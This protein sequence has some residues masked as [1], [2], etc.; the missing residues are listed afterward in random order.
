MEHI[1][2]RVIDTYRELP[3]LSAISIIK[4]PY[5][6]N[7]LIDGLDMLVLL[8]TERSVNVESAEHVQLDNERALIRIVCRDDMDKWIAGGEN[9]NII[10]WLVRG[11]IWLDRYGYLASVRERLLL[12]PESMREQKQFIEFTG[13]LRTYLQ[14]KQDLLDGNLLDAYSHVLTALHHWAHIVLIEEGRHPELTVWKQLR[15]VHPGVYKLYEELTASPETLEQRVHLV[16]LACEFSVMSKMK[17][18]CSILLDIMN[19]REEPWSIGELQDH[20]AI[21]FLQVE[22]SLV[23]HKLVKRA[24]VREV[25]VMQE[26]KESGVLELKYMTVAP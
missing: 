15:R 5:P 18:C 4:N 1:R 10:E 16:M 11:E 21:S 7:P 22:L 14:A 3:G 26:P 9:R 24:Y 17:V 20:P 2:E 8:V 6:Y 12:F 23:I 25:A 13:F 19:S